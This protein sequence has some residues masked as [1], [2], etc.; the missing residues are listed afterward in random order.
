MRTKDL[1]LFSIDNTIS[2]RQNCVMYGFVADQ[3]LSYD[4]SKISLG[5]VGQDRQDKFGQDR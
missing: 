2:Q 4:V 5:K 1:T 3:K